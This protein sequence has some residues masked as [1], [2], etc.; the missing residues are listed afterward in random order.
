MLYT[1]GFR[2]DVARVAYWM[3]SGWYRRRAFLNRAI[4]AILT[5]DYHI[6]YENLT[7][8]VAENRRVRRFAGCC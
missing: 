8:R 2:Y 7:L 3:L 4:V 5:S 1:D 6:V